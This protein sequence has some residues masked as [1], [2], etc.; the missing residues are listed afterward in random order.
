MVEKTV[1]R[2]IALTP[3]MRD[4]LALLASKQP[5][6]VTEADLIR[7]AI[8]RYLDEQADL[9]GSRKHFQ[10]SFQDRMDKVEAA[11]GFHLNIVLF[12]VHQLTPHG[13]KLLER[14]PGALAD[15]EIL[16]MLLFFAFKKGDTKPLAKA[17]INQLPAF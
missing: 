2:S 6:N 7:E 16:E 4:Q 10:K 3:V 14:G 17:L 11:L 13:D 9:L 15:Y 1:R 5:R 12:M 8:R